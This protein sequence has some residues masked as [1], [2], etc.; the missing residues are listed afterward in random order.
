MLAFNNPTI[1]TIIITDGQELTF[2]VVLRFLFHHEK[3]SAIAK[4]LRM[5]SGQFDFKLATQRQRGALQK[6]E[7]RR[8][9]IFGKEKVERRAA[10]FHAAG[11]L[12]PGNATAFHLL[13]DLPGHDTAMR[14]GRTF[15]EQAVLLQKVV[16]V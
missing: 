16:E 14:T 2:L 4:P 11:E 15:R 1:S 5:A 8:S 9:F 13:F 12:R 10:G 3:F 7:G 6:L